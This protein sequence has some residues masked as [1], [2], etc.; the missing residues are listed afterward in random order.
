MNS[1]ERESIW[2]ITPGMRVSYFIIF[3]SVT[4]IGTALLVWNTITERGDASASA[5]ALDIIFG[6]SAIGVSAAT[7]AITLTEGTR[8]I[9]VIAQWF[10]DTYIKPS[11]ERREKKWRDAG[12][13]AGRAELIAEI[14]DWEQRRNAATENGEDFTEPPPYAED[15][16]QSSN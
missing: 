14:R 4:V 8:Y 7:I 2:S 6:I 9:M 10:E 3:A 12:K 5:I 16:D 13:D 15:T 11:R 1:E